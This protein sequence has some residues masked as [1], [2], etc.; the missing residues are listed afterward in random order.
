METK[1]KIIIIGPAYPY[2]GGNALFVAHTY[3]AL[4]D[5]YIEITSNTQKQR[6]NTIKSLKNTIVEAT[7]F[8][9]N[10]EDLERTYKAT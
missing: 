1:K 5:Q 2:R 7:T 3:E 8:R 4:K 10:V 9:F 6:F